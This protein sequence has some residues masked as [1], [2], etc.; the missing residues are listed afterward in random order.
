M[1]KFIVGMIGV[2]LLSGCST[3]SVNETANEI[4]AEARPTNVLPTND[5]K[6]DN[7]TQNDSTFYEPSESPAVETSE[8]L[9]V[10]SPEES[11]PAKQEPKPVESSAPEPSPTASEKPSEPTKEPEAVYDTV[12]FVDNVDLC[13]I[14]EYTWTGPHSKGFPIRNNDV[15]YSGIVNVAVIP[16]DFSDAT[17]NGMSSLSTYKKYFDF[18]RSWSNFYSDGKM[19]YNISIHTEWLRAPKKATEY[20]K[21]NDYAE[22][23]QMQDWISVADPYY[24]FSKTHFVYFVVPEKAHFE[25]GADMYGPGI[26][27][28]DEGQLISRVF[29][30]AGEPNK[31]WSHLVHEILHDQGF[32]G[33]GPANGSAYGVM[34]G[35]WNQSL[36]VLSWPSFLAGWLDSD[37]I[38]CI[39]ARKQFAT[40]IIQVESLDALG[41]SP[42][43]KSVIL[44]TGETTAT[45]VEY[46]TDGKFSTLSELRHGITAYNLDTSKPSNRCDSCGPQE[47]EDRKN[48]WNYIRKPGTFDGGG[49][50]N[51][52]FKSGTIPN[53]TGFTIKILSKNIIQISK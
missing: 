13:K 39:D 51:F 47:Y 42:G 29:T 3:T 31:I 49:N 37:D 19:T 52:N 21:R 11:A 45:V 46:R 48:W 43:I 36:S 1:K 25:L 2:A 26:A 30:Y 18:A 23:A 38:V 53:T 40:S 15:P 8:S 7:Q 9:G 20:P 35:Q 41:A 14:P 17:S 34:M 32:I 33:H 5:H 6:Q 22:Y 24:D 27:N 10:S 28:T 44:R 4:V 16:I 12:S 50:N